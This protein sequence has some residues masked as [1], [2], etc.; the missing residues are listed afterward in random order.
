MQYTLPELPYT[1]DALEPAIDATTMEI[2]HSKHHAGYVDKLNALLAEHEVV[3]MSIEELFANISAYPLGIRNNAGGHYNHA[4]FWESLIPGGSK[5]PAELEAMIS[6]SFESVDAFKERFNAAALSRFGSGWAWL[7]Y[8]A[9]TGELKI[10]STANQD[11][12]LMDVVR[13]QEGAFTPV[14][15]IDV[16]EHAYYLKYQNRRAEYMKEIWQV[17]NWEKVQERIVQ[18]QA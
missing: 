4:M 16:W 17:I 10:F 18:A 1:Y 2:H 7:G 3:D 13:E 15:G 12:P 14:L 5:V 11:N 6:E 8:S 9:D